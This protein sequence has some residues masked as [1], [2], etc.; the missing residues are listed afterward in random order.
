MDPKRPKS[1]W[2]PALWAFLHTIAV[3]DHDEPDIRQKMI[4]DCLIILRGIEHVIPCH[5]CVAFWKEF[6]ESLSDIK[7]SI[8]NENMGL[9]RLLWEFHNKVNVKLGKPTIEYDTAITIYCRGT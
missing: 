2:G 7:S 9:F 5:K 4:A 6:M 8:V 3:I 1:H